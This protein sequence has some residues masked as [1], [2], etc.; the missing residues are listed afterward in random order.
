MSTPTVPTGIVEKGTQL[1]TVVRMRKSLVLVLAVPMIAVALYAR[2]APNSDPSTSPAVPS[3]SPDA[4]QLPSTFAAIWS[5]CDD[6]QD[7][8][9]PRSP[10][11][12]CF[13]KKIPD[14]G[15]YAYTDIATAVRALALQD[16]DFS[17][18]CHQ[19]NHT[20]AER[21]YAL[22]RIY[23]MVSSDDGLCFWSFTHGTITEFAQTATEEE[24]LDH[25]DDICANL[26]S[27]GHVEACAH[28]LGHGIVIRANDSVF[29]AEAYCAGAAEYARRGC[30]QAVIMSYADGEA[31]QNEGVNVKLDPIEPDV[32]DTLCTKFSNA[33]LGE[34]WRVFWL[35]YPKQMP[36]AE[37]SSRTIAACKLTPAE[38]ET[39]CYRGVGESV[40]WRSREIVS[41]VKS[42]QTSP[43]AA[44]EEGMQVCEKVDEAHRSLCMS[45]VGHAFPNVWVEDNGSLDDFPDVCAL[46]PLAYR[47]GC[48]T[49]VTEFTN[50]FNLGGTRHEQSTPQKSPTEK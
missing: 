27:V 36:V 26:P 20:I 44:F 10:K 23:D 8:S 29:E 38:F 45:G 16:S 46:V 37:A 32:V 2:F 30:V 19:A 12:P 48:K 49:G 25:L 22:E 31:S 17:R 47:E 9:T 50:N 1:C 18:A 43:T 24:F 35:L 13:L 42:V 40:I 21:L 28:G 6:E 15:S 39:S 3:S 5:D 7:L 4:S 33:S 11:I 41:D 14:L 34:C